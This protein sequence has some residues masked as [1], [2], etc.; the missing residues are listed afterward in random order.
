M[1][2]LPLQGIAIDRLDY[3][4]AFNYDKD[5]GISWVP[6]APRAGAEPHGAWPHTANWTWGAARANRL[7]Y[8]HTYARLHEVLKRARHGKGGP[9]MNNCN[10][11][12]NVC[13]LDLLKN[14]DVCAYTH[15]RAHTCISIM[16]HTYTAWLHRAHSLRAPP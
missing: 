16:Q 12:G 6:L 11:L 15:M 4:E 7:S 2:L 8:R 5:D 10:A 3:S 9:M 13:R 1:L 14:F